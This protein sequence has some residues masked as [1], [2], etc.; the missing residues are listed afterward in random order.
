MISYLKGKIILKKEKSVVLVANNVGYEVFL[1]PSTIEKI[2]SSKE[3]SF[4]CSPRMRKDLWEIY[5][6]S[7]TDELNLFEF[8]ITV[9]G[10]GPKA[11]L[12]VS[13]IG[14][15]DKLKEGI[16][17][18]DNIVLSR[19]FKIGKKKAQ[20][21]IFE[22]SRELKSPQNEKKKIDEIAKPLLSLGFTKAEIK[23]AV[24][25]LPKK[26]DGLEEEIK[27]TLKILGQRK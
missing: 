13:S 1:A 19:L 8:L 5:G 2:S 26:I 27:E 7:S 14:S 9:S 16:K 25:K 11:A 21:I 20:A 15:I 22:I 12:E 6:F 3:T 4:F 17:K 23:E 10:I 24:K 18:D